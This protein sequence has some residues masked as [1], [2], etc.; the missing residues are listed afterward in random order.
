VLTKY[1]NGLLEKERRIETEN[2]YCSV[3]A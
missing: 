2:G 1:V 3:T